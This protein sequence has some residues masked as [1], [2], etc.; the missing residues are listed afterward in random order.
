MTFED[1]Y[2]GSKAASE[3]ETQAIQNA[4]LNNI[5]NWE[6]FLTLH[7]FGGYW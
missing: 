7:S 4:I 1:I 2:A 6:A 5:G 3:L